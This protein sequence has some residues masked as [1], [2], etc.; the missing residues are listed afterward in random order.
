MINRYRI[1]KWSDG[2]V[3]MDRLKLN[4]CIRDKRFSD[5]VFTSKEQALEF[6]HGKGIPTEGVKI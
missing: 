3:I 1:T 2:Y 5:K 6:L 4:T